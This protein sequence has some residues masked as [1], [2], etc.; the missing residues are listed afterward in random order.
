M[1]FVEYET[2]VKIFL[3]VAGGFTN[4]QRFEY[5]SSI[6]NNL[7]SHRRDFFFHV[8]FYNDNDG[9]PGS[10]TNRF[11]ISC[12][13]NGGSANLPKNPLDPTAV[14]VTGW[15]TFRHRFYDS[16][17]VLAVDLTLLDPSDAL[18]NT[19]TLSNPTDVI[20]L[21]GGNR[22]ALIYNSDFGDFFAFDDTKL[23]A[24]VNRINPS[25]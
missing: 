20:G 6:N 19:W 12:N 4:D 9:S 7:G 25:E 10:G 18:V 14:S 23:T 5:T 8:G 21:I 11:I 15:Y 16:G 1:P 2:E 22:Y 3:N 13:N 17:G 24:M